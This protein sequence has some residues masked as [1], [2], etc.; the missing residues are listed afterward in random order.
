MFSL[1]DPL[2]PALPL[3]G[4]SPVSQIE[5]HPSREETF[6]PGSPGELTGLQQPYSFLY[7]QNT[8][9]FRGLHLKQTGKKKKKK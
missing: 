2:M 5:I 3:P 6:M 1:A 9:P 4:V 8:E 7:K